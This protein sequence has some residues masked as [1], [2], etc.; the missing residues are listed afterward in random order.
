MLKVR[1]FVKNY[2]YIDCIKNRINTS[3]FDEDINSKL[4]II[5]EAYK[6]QIIKYFKI[7]GSNKLLSDTDNHKFKADQSFIDG[8]VCYKDFNGIFEE[9]KKDY[10]NIIPQIEKLT[11]VIK[12][13]TKELFFHN[14]K[15]RFTECLTIKQIIILELLLDYICKLHHNELF[16]VIEHT[17][18]I[19]FEKFIFN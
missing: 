7:E 4:K 1:I 5:Y 15:Y 13:V 6:N 14:D 19:E 16:S 18:F 9:L 2:N 8:Y 10:K 12:R 17:N 11:S 3:F